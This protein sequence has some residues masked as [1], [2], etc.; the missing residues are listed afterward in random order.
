MEN[1]AYLLL[2]LGALLPLVIIYLSR[3]SLRRSIIRIGLIGGVAGLVAE[4]FYLRDYWRPVGVIPNFPTFIEDFMFG[5]AITSLSAV[6]YG[7]IT[8]KKL[9]R[10]FEPRSKVFVGLFLFGLMAMLICNVWLGG[11]SI[12]VSSVVFI[13]ISAFILS[14]RKDLLQPALVTSVLVTL[15]MFLVYVVVFYILQPNWWNEHWLLQGT[16]LDIKIWGSIPLTEM[17]W[18]GSW[19]LLAS[20][21][22]PYLRGKKY[23]DTLV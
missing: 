13:V 14:Q 20:I 17:V 5:F 18:Y 1:Y 11:A 22:S 12:V 15:Y 3:A 23:T 7:Y 8:N 19:A 10:A 4:L 16:A 2:D 21:L 6:L 9:E